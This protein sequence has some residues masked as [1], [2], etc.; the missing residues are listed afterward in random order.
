MFF[1]GFQTISF[2]AARKEKNAAPKR[3]SSP[4]NVE[5]RRSVQT[6]VSPQPDDTNVDQE[7]PHSRRS[8][9][10]RQVDETKF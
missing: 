6:R 3:V 8:H 2:V 10:K 9:G 5:K 7:R 1:D 4:K